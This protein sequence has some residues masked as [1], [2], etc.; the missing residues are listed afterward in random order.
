MY[1]LKYEDF[2]TC[3]IGVTVIDSKGRRGKVNRIVVDNK[4]VTVRYTVYDHFVGMGF[5]SIS[6]DGD[7]T[8]KLFLEPEQLMLWEFS[9]N[10]RYRNSTN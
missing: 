3:I 4:Y 2:D 7:D 5:A 8:K 10:E 1:E 6:K 9:R